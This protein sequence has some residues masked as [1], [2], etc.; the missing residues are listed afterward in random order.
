MAYGEAGVLFRI[1]GDYRVAQKSK[2]LPN[3]PKIVLKPANE[4]RFIR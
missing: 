1:P 4:I 3:D 2:P